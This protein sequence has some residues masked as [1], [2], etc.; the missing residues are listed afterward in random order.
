MTLTP[1]TD[2]QYEDLLRKMLETVTSLNFEPTCVDSTDI[3]DKY[4]RSNCGLCNDEYTTIETAM[5]PDQFPQR[6]TM[7][8]RGRN[9]KCPYDMRESVIH[10]EW[11]CFFKCRLFQGKRPI[12][13]ETLRTDIITTLQQHQAGKL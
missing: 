2:E 3:G 13:V 6:K 11:S 7:K 10:W 5:W 1:L 12:Q 8:Y 4:T 9:H